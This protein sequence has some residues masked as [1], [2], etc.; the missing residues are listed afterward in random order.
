MT[1]VTQT[2]NFAKLDENTIK[3]LMVKAAQVG[4]SKVCDIWCITLV[5]NVYTMQQSLIVLY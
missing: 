4:A 3:S 5:Y 1:A 2:A